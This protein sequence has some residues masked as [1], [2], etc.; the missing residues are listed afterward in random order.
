MSERDCAGKEAC[1]VCGSVE[2]A[3]AHF[4]AGRLICRACW[5]EIEASKGKTR[6]RQQSLDLGDLV[7][8]EGVRR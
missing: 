4:T 8:R 3:A 1:A 5:R 6:P 7:Q 2:W